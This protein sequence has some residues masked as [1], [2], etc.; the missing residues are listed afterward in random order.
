MTQVALPEALRL[1]LLQEARAA[2][3]RECCG[4]VE[5]LRSGDAYRVMALHAAR[6]LA[7]ATDRFEIAPQDHIRALK[8]ARANGHALIGCYHSH[9]QGRAEPS[10]TDGR[11]AA[12]DDFLW[13]IV[14]GDELAGFVYRRGTFSGV[15]FLP[16]R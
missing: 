4:L 1:R 11:G 9:P 13:L 16:P 15:G 10:A 8:A 5:G 3:P 2:F 6:N 14:A 7:S 12:E